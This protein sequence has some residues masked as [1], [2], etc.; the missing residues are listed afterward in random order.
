MGGGAAAERRQPPSQA[1]GTRT[2]QR[3]HDMQAI[4]GWVCGFVCQQRETQQLSIWR[5]G[6]VGPHLP[7]QSKAQ[8]WPPSRSAH[9]HW[10]P[11]PGHWTLTTNESG[12]PQPWVAKGADA[13]LAS[14]PRTKGPCT[15]LALGLVLVRVSA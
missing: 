4:E 15:W 3:W 1:L 5:A 10:A 12:S 9:T 13:Q 6:A 7:R 8:G 2:E 14:Y 11:L